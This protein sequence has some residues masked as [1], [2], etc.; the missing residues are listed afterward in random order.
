MIEVGRDIWRLF[1]LLPPTQAGPATEDRMVWL[2]GTLKNIKSKPSTIV[3][4]EYSAWCYST[5]FS[6]L[7]VDIRCAFS[8]AINFCETKSSVFD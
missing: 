4:D 6:L 1:G 8:S 5:A 2:E 3:K 7:C